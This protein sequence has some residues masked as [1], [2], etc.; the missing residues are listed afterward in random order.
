MSIKCKMGIHHWDGCICTECNTIRST[1]HDLTE[2]CEKCSKCGTVF[3]NNHDWSKNCEKCSKCGKTRE[4]AHFWLD[5]CEKCTKC[6]QVRENKH[7]MSNGVCTICGH[8]IFVDEDKKQYQ[9]IRIGDNILMA[10]NYAK[11]TEEGNCW[12]YEDNNLNKDIYGCL[13]DYETAKMMAPT[14]WHLPS[15]EEWES[16][17]KTVGGHSEFGYENLKVGGHSGFDTIFTGMRSN[18]GNYVGEKASAHYWSITK[19]KENT[20]WHFK[21]LVYNHDAELEIVD[22]SQ[23]MSV[24][25]FKDK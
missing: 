21:V 16:V 8:G 5:N 23:G 7:K 4:D 14:G 6:G 10:E 22:I 24:R 2:D 15:L 25:Y 18:Y 19:D 1:H 11:K 9:I 17:R 20:A 13:Y 3:E 12:V